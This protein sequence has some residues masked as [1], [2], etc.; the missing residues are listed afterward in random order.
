MKTSVD[1]HRL[2]NIEIF[3]SCAKSV[4][5]A[6]QIRDEHMRKNDIAVLPEDKLLLW[7]ISSVWWI[8]GLRKC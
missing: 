6:A 5:E 3:N 1:K 8:P 7:S 4:S 2:S